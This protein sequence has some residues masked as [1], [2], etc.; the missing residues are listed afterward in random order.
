[1][2]PLWCRRTIWIRETGAHIQQEGSIVLK[3][4]RTPVVMKW[5]CQIMV[6]FSRILDPPLGVA[7]QSLGVTYQSLGVTYQSLWVTTCK[8]YTVKVSETCPCDRALVFRDC[9]KSAYTIHF[10]HHLRSKTIFWPRR[11]RSLYIP[12]LAHSC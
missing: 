3:V 5:V 10:N 2:T 11:G 12:L 7:Y 6:C 1:M 8:C 4:S 9:P